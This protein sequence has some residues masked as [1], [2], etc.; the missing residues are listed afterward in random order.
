[1]R[2]YL[3]AGS[4]PR[5]GWTN[6]DNRPLPDIQIV[7]DVLRGLPFTDDSVDEIA[8]E[9]FMEHIPQEEVIWMMNEMHRVLK[10]DGTMSHSIALANTD[11]FNQAPDHL[12]H[13]IPMTLEFFTKGHKK[14]E[15][16]GD[17]IKPWIVSS[18]RIIS[19]GQGMQVTLKKP[20]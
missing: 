19:E 4:S 13:W 17:A 14:N 1:M 10:P 16:Y 12:S 8:S 6:I 18:C 3:G 5:E 15:Y 2:I 9:N 7:R 20:V 11:N